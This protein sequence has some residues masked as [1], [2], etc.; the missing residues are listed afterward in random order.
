M[1]HLII[2]RSTDGSLLFIIPTTNPAA[3]SQSLEGAGWSYRSVNRQKIALLKAK[4][5]CSFDIADEDSE[6][7]I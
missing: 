1:T 6:L 4:Q 3:V 2:Y 5:F 7:A